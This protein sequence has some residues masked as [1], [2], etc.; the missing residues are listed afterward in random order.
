MKRV[1]YIGIAGLC[2]IFLPVGP[3]FS[4]T[5]GS[6][7][8]TPEARLQ[9]GVSLYGRGY[10][11]EAVDELRQVYS[12]ASG[13]ALKADA[14]YWISMTELAAG[15]YDNS[16]R[17]M[18]ELER[19]TPGNAKYAEIPYHRGRVYY[20]LGR[21]DEAISLFRTY[22]DSIAVDVPGES[23]RKP[24]ALYW[25]GECL[26]AM[27]QLNRAQD[28]FSQI[29]EQYPQSVKY[30]A[31][32]YRLALINQKKIEVELL[33]IVKWSHE[34]SLKT[35]EEYQRREK[36]YDQ[37]IIAYQKKIAEMLKDTY[38]AGLEASNAGYRKRLSEAEAKITD[39]EKKLEEANRYL[40]AGNR[41]ENQN[42][43]SYY[44]PNQNG[45]T[46]NAGSYVDNTA[47]QNSSNTTPIEYSAPSENPAPRFGRIQDL[48]S[49]STQL[50][51]ELNQ[52]L[53][54]R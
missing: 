35:V 9:Y 26:Y 3:L 47:R 42:Q 32:S 4:Q 11:P 50:I 31:S 37:A 36:S 25:M 28:I 5:R 22:I 10:W 21:Y 2:L 19:L 30:E 52:M 54:A 41:R 44:P 48:R 51:T 24:A 45:Y 49:S 34:E 16:I 27:G 33:S 14:L 38:L 53:N 23:A 40:S 29:V 15:N 18:D 1:F 46:E 17:A 7:D 13:A 20:Y 39:L 6:Y 43:G 8:L 12:E